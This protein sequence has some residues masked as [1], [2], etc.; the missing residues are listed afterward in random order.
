MTKLLSRQ[1]L[2]TV[3]VALLVLTAGCSGLTGGDQ[4]DAGDDSDEEEEDDEDEETEPTAEAEAGAT[5]TATETDD[6]GGMMETET[7]SMESAFGTYQWTRGEQYD[8]SVSIPDFNQELTWEVTAV[9]GSQVTVEVTSQTGDRTET[10]T[11]EGAQGEIFGQAA[12]SRLAG[13]YSSLRAAN[14]V[15][16]GRDLTVGNSWEVSSGDLAFRGDG[17]IET[18]TVEV[19]GTDSYAGVECTVLELTPD[20][21]EGTPFTTCVN[22]DRPFAPYFETQTEQGNEISIELTAASR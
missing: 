10:T 2:A 21:E 17:D 1:V 20:N 3:L 22:Q 12:E 13:F 7:P 14:L 11:L 15:G 9:Q 4:A 8:Y 19:T 5:E 16:E 18:A 6:G